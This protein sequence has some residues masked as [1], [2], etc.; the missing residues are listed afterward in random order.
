MGDKT[1]GNALGE[2]AYAK[3]IAE[4][5]DMADWKG[6]QDA[7]KEALEDGGL[8][9]LLDTAYKSVYED[10]TG[11]AASEST[12][13][14]QHAT[15]VRS[16]STILKEIVTEIPGVKSVKGVGQVLIRE[17]LELGKW[18]PNQIESSGIWQFADNGA[19]AAGDRDGDPEY[20][21]FGFEVT[22]SVVSNLLSDPKSGVDVDDVRA[23]DSRLVEKGPDGEYRLRPSD[24]LLKAN[25]PP[26]SDQHRG[27]L[28]F[29]EANAALQQ[30][31]DDKTGKLYESYVDAFI[32]QR[33]DQ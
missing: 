9:G 13:D 33:K 28:D 14:K 2:A 25:D 1:A 32:D 3:V 24:E 23:I 12:V 6:W 21:K 8:I 19:P 27:N 22:H 7:R 11:D 16:A 31:F 10:A 15:W 18:S 17:A 30:L 5:G 20:E 29:R 26:S 4:A